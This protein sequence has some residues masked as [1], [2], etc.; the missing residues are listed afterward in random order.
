MNGEE[1]Y[2]NLLN[3]TL[4]KGKIKENRTSVSCITTTP[5]MIQHDM[6]K[7]FPLLT[8]KKMALKT[9]ATELEFFIKGYTD[10]KWLKDRKCNIWNPWCNPMKMPDNLSEEER[11][12]FQEQ[13]NDL[14]YIYGYQWRNFNSQGHDQ[15]KETVYKLKNNPN[16][17]RM[18][19][20]SWNPLQF[21]Q[22]AL[23]PCHMMWGVQILD[24]ELNLW[25]VQRS[26]DEFLGLPFNLASYGL[27]LKLLS[28]ESNFKE[29]ILTG[30]LVDNHIYYNHVN[31][32]KT[33]LER[34]PYE[35]PDLEIPDF[36]N[37]FNWNSSQIEV[38]N[39]NYHSA[40]KAPIA[41]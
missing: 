37:I 8:T 20:S 25:W 17:R 35:L 5:T 3:N 21:H 23:P 10:K 28:L 38:K 30:F 22:M 33:Q 13:E 29:G 15:L 31:Q 2:L 24:N 1:N 40:I 11:K 18:V 32:V 39:Y 36:N 34:K 26:V 7:G 12:A 14:G 9:M 6:S 19:V 41:V 16:D 4:E 27:L